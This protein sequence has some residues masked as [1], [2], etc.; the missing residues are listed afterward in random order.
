MNVCESFLLAISL[1][2]FDYSGVQNGNLCFCGQSYDKYGETD[3][4]E[5]NKACVGD[6]EEICGGSLRNSVFKKHEPVEEKY[7]EIELDLE[8]LDDFVFP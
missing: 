3:P 1:V 4:K 8:S 7:D 2:D 6:T 5:C